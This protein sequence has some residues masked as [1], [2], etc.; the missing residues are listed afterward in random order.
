MG[1]KPEGTEVWGTTETYKGQANLDRVYFMDKLDPHLQTGW[2][3][4]EGLAHWGGKVYTLKHYAGIPKSVAYPIDDIIHEF[5]KL[6]FTSSMSYM[7]AH[8]IYEKVDVI[9]LHKVA[10]LAAS[11]EYYHQKDCLDFWCGVALGRGIK[12]IVSPDSYL[13]KASPWCSTLYG[14]LVNE[15]EDYANLTLRPALVQ[16]MAIPRSFYVP[17]PEATPKM[18]REP[19]TKDQY[20]FK[21][22]VSTFQTPV[23][24]HM[25]YKL[26]CGHRLQVV[27]GE[28]PK[29]LPDTMGCPTC[30]SVEMEQEQLKKTGTLLDV[31]R[32]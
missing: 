31:Q 20:P 18:L 15:Y 2:E 30:W 10:T 4:L 12:V 9:N 1:E 7:L 27:S 14:Y 19:S 5:E 13:M 25:Q 8:A 11:R 6:Y 22:V 3:N 23:P 26:E 21:K 17:H 29:K 16:A 32:Y 24:V 28:T